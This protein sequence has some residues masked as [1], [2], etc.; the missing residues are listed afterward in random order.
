MAFLEART[1]RSKGANL[2]SWLVG[3][4]PIFLEIK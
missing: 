2:K 4:G 1:A 3:S